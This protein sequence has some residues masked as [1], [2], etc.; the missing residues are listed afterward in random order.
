M[1][2][3]KLFQ[4]IKSFQSKGDYIIWVEYNDDGTKDVYS[5]DSVFWANFFTVE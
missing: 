5:T 4:E 3:G 2:I 1:E